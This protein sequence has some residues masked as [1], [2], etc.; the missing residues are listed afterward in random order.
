MRRER[1]KEMKSQGKE[2]ESQRKEMESQGKEEVLSKQLSCIPCTVLFYQE[3]LSDRIR[4]VLRGILHLVER[5]VAENIEVM[6]CLLFFVQEG[7]RRFNV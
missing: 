4:D 6:N 3:S 5:Q 7:L 2:M 1:R